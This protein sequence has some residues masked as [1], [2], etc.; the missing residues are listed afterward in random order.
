M[1][2]INL[3]E[4]GLLINY[5]RIKLLFMLGVVLHVSIVNVCV[6]GESRLSC[7][8]PAVLSRLRPKGRVR[9]FV[10]H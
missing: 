7:T 2:S 8:G 6:A 5:K 4:S 9:T 1:E 10:P 3:V